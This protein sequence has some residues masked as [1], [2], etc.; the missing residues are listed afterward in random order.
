MNLCAQH[1]LILISRSLLLSRC[2]WSKDFM[3]AGF[4]TASIIAE[5]ILRENQ[6]NKKSSEYQSEKL[7][8]PVVKSITQV[9][10]HTAYNSKNKWT[11]ISD[12]ETNIFELKVGMKS[13]LGFFILKFYQPLQRYLLTCQ[14][15]SAFLGRFF[16][17]TMY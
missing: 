13:G 15:N 4:Y 12:L 7:D 16:L 5:E 17:V 10:M 14:A 3:T 2:R 6:K 1:Y 9:N 11:K 8:N